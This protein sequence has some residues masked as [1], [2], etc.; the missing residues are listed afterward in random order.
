MKVTK[1]GNVKR[2]KIDIYL[3]YFSIKNDVYVKT[4]FH[5]G[6]DVAN[7][8]SISQMIYAMH[9]TDTMQY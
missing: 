1:V 9:T 5:Y 2:S 7:I 4:L 8:H 3:F 6:I